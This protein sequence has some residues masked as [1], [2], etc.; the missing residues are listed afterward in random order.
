[1]KDLHLFL[2]SSPTLC[3]SSIYLELMPVF[4]ILLMPSESSISFYFFFTC[5]R[6]LRVFLHSI[7]LRICL[8][9][10]NKAR[11]TKKWAPLSFFLT[12]QW[13]LGLNYVDGIRTREKK[14]KKKIGEEEVEL[15]GDIGRRR[16]SSSFASSATRSTQTCCQLLA[17]A[18][19]G[20]V[21]PETSSTFLI[22]P[23]SV[24]SSR[25]G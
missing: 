2:L 23:P 14:K 3:L 10:N 4:L 18:T 19:T 21:P 11:H 13:W 7:H 1:M 25:Q 6:F 17:Q 15:D 9:F 12:V 8:T 16:R 22:P 24:V 5:I 20:R